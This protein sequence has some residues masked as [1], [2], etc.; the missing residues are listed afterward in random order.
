MPECISQGMIVAD[1][2]LQCLSNAVER[3]ADHILI[4]DAH[5][6][7]LYTNP[8][9][10]RLTGYTRRETYGLTPRLLK[11]GK[12][13][14]SSYR[15][16]WSTL[17]AGNV[18]RGTFANRKKSGQLYS[19]GQTITPM[20]DGSGSITH[21]VSVGR[22]L[23]ER[24][25][26]EDR[27][28]EMRLA[29][30]VQSRLYPPLLRREG[31]DIAGST[32]PASATGGDYYDYLSMREG[33]LGIVVADVS[34]HGLGAALIM[35]ATRAALRS[36]ADIA[37]SLDEILD[38]VNTT[39]LS[40]LEPGRF[41]TMCLASLDTQALTLTYSNAGHPS[42]Y[43]LSGTGEI[44]CVMESTRIP[45]GVMSDWKGQP[46]RSIPLERGDILVFLTDGVLDSMGGDGC[47][48]E[49]ENVLALVREHR[50][51]SAQQILEHVLNGVQMARE[52]VPQEDDVTAVICKVTA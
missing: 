12:Q 27:D 36:C 50:L 43:V 34:G 19:S 3:T 39:L 41:V 15:G 7:I 13:D 9:F 30:L 45:L 51:E 47:P 21:F 18:F 28:S 44:K 46:T 2:A 25:A 40:D 11:S 1:R 4:T 35:V 16:L 48:F 52:G 26:I 24:E 49:V 8:A 14:P 20:R 31:I 42:G 29:G 22:D 32:L 38:H 17:L 6:T 5:G 23:T 10:E 33:R 37:I